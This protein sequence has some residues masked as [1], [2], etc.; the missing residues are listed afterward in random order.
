[1]LLRTVF[2][3]AFLAISAQSI[4]AGAGA[5]AKVALQRR[6]LDAADS[7][8]TSGVRAAQSAVAQSIAAS[9]GTASLL[10][11]TAIATCAYADAAGCELNVRTT[12]A[13]PTPAAAPPPQSCPQTDC[14]VLLQANTSVAEGRVALLISSVVSS[15]SG[16]QLASRSGLAAFRTYATPPYASLVG[17]VD[18]SVDALMNGGAADDG[19]SPSTLITVEYVPSNGAS[20]VPAN[21]WQPLVETS[22]T[23]APAWER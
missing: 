21:V 13:T 12:F 22:A 14:T 8:F 9:G 18:A 5:L 1:V 3:L 16:A 15:P 17:G 19:G 2:L 4:V 6:A 10:V 20:G 23:S 7:G 11:P